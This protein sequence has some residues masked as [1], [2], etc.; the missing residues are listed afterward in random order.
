[1]T[2]SLSLLR[3][4]GNTVGDFAGW[5]SP[6]GWKMGSRGAEAR[7]DK[8]GQRSVV[9]YSLERWALWEMMGSD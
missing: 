5:E 9:A 1:M 4:E 8:G 7:R 6:R 3:V 2:A